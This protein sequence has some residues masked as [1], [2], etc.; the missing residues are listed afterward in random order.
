MITSAHPC[1]QVDDCPF[2]VN[3]APFEL[4]SIFRDMFIVPPGVDHKPKGLVDNDPIV[5]QGV[6]K[7]LFRKFL[8]ILF[9]ELEFA[10]PSRICIFIN[11]SICP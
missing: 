5:L 3:R 2:K 4:S 6:T 10:S 11:H 1:V 7:D 8:S 9:A